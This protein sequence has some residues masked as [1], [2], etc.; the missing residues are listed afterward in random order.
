MMGNYSK[1]QEENNEVKEKDKVRREKL[2]GLFFDLAK[3]SFAGLVVGGIV[4]MKPDIDITLDIYR[5][6]IGGISTIV[7]IR[8][9]NTIL[10]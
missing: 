6:I 8:I 2:A 4:S 3:L 10:K 1:K 7:F 9:G 5:V